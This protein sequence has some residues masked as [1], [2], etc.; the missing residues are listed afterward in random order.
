MRVLKRDG[1]YEDV[2]FD[3]V[4]R[5]IK[6]LSNGLD[7]VETDEVAQKI[8]GRIYDGVKTTELDELT[9]TTCSTMSTIHPNYG[10]LASRIIISNMHK[11]TPDTFSEAIEKLYNVVDIHGNNT[12]LI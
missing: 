6:N 9:A 8:C 5:R 7:G 1:E 4:L 2:S 3:K 12:P 10:I 11:I